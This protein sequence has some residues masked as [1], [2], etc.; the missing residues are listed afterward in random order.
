MMLVA[1]GAGVLL[2][3]S[4]NASQHAMAR[5]L[6]D[7]CRRVPQGAAIHYLGQDDLWQLLNWEAETYRQSIAT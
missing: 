2:H 1:P 6:A 7:V 3:R 4:A 5:C